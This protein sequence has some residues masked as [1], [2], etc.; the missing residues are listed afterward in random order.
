MIHTPAGLPAF[1]ADPVPA[2]AGEW[3]RITKTARRRQQR[4]MAATTSV[5]ALAAA[6]PLALFWPNDDG[7]RD[8]VR[9]APVA[10]I[11]GVKTYDPDSLG[12]NHLS[13]PVSYPQTPPVGG[14]HAGEPQQCGVYS[15]P[16]QNENAVHSLEHG[17][18]WITYRNDI[19][20]EAVR[21][22]EEVAASAQPWALMSPLPEQDELI[23]ITAWGRQLAV[24]DAAD[25][26]LA[27]F[28]RLYANSP[29]APEPDP[30]CTGTTSTRPQ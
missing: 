5:L 10:G 2:P 12:R 13:G 23:V 29:Q 3:Q 24:S 22:L 7:A 19:N 28:A 17:A 6:A 30:T 15:A 11:P 20:S 8:T 21:R 4:R 1:N 16:V 25:P 27:R 14:D 9:P 18:V 26:R